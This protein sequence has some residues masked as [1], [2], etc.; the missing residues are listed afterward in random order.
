MK[1]LL[2]SNLFIITLQRILGGFEVSWQIQFLV[3]TYSQSFTQ[4]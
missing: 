3:D 2:L 1:N 4:L